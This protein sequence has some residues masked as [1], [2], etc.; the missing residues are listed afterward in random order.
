M[1]LE[2]LENVEHK[3]S[4]EIE[5]KARAINGILIY[6]QEKPN[7]LGDFISVALIDG[8]ELHPPCFFTFV[9]PYYWKVLEVALIVIAS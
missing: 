8:Y 9:S 4:L 7:G 1:E 2:P 3:F 5:F 6:A